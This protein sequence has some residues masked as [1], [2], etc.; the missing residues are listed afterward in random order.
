M[1]AGHGTRIMI[2]I[3]VSFRYNSRLELMDNCVFVFVASLVANPVLSR[4][5][6]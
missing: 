6:G 3:T 1:R 5:C 4:G 2:G